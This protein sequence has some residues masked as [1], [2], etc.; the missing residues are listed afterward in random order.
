[1]APDRTESSFDENLPFERIGPY[2]LVRLLGEGGMSRVFE[3]VQDAPRRTVAIKLMREAAFSATA[4]RRFDYEGR[5]LAGLRHPGIARVI[6]AGTLR[7]DGGSIPYLVMEHIP[8]ARTFI[9]YARHASLSMHERLQLFVRVCETVHYGHG[10]GVIHRDLKPGNIL[11]DDEGAVKVIDFGVARATEQDEAP[12]QA[13]TATG[14]LVG[15]LQYMSP[16]QCEADP[17]H[18][19]VRSDVYALGVLLFEL[20]TDEMPYD[21]KELGLIE[22][23]KAIRS[24]PPKTPSTLNPKLKGDLEIVLLKALEKERH[25]RYQTAIELYEDINR[26]LQP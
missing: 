10:K 26:F 15:T 1:M 16:E 24:D 12:A 14:Q 2:R 6:E 18:L 22:A 3:A 23:A 4:L 25:L 11:V 17:E 7:S 21:L 20:L 8:N 5:I 9:D 19:D 13:R